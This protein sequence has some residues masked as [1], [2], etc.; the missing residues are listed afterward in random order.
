MRLDNLPSRRVAE[1][2]GATFESIT[3]NR[4]MLYAKAL[5]GAIYSIVPEPQ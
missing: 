2:V 5:E 1:K 3:R 4:T